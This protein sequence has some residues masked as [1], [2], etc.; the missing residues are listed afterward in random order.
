MRRSLVSLSLLLAAVA[1]H[2]QTTIDTPVATVRLT[3]QE[4]ISQ[5]SLKTDFDRL[6][7]VAKRKLTPEER[8]QVLDMRINNVLFFQFCER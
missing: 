1:L 8:K 2:A 5:R 6:E 7:T 4:V 3:R